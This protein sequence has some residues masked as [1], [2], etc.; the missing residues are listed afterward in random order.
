MT[1]A[2]DLSFV[3]TTL[4]DGSQSL[5]SLNMTTAMMVP[6]LGAINAVGYDAVEVMSTAEFKKCVRDLK[7]DP[8]QRLRVLRDGLPD[9]RRRFIRGRNIGTFQVF[10]DA[11]EHL[12]T[13]RLAANGVSELRISDSSN[14]P[15]RWAEQTAL[16]RANGLGVVLNVIYSLSPKHTDAY[17]AERARAAAAL[18]PDGIC[19]KDPGALITPDRTQTLVPIVLAAAGG[20]PVEFHT[21]CLTG[22]GAAC[23]FEAMRLGVAC[24]NTATPPLANGASNP[25]VFTALANARA[26]GRRPTID[27][28]LLP[29]VERHFTEVA[30]RNGFPVGRPLDF[31]YGQYVHQVPGGMISN[32]RFQLGRMGMAERLPAILEETGRVR[33]ELGHPIMVTP[34]SQFV[35]S[36]AAVNVITGQRY[37]VLTDEVIQFALGAWGEEEANGIDPDVRD[38]ILGS[39]RAKELARVAVPQPSLDEVRRR[40]GGPGV[41]DEAMLLRIATDAASV[42]AMR[43]G[44]ASLAPDG[45]AVPLT[46]LIARLDRLPSTRHVR[47]EKAGLSLTLARA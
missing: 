37:G 10:P 41:S 27:D 21:H 25:S 7:E 22:L 43:A 16:A 26:L 33:A 2:P 15:A 32:F 20:I 47:I 13:E 24:V 36:Q 3:D 19:L 12:W 31:D 18:K 11:V 44:G 39:A 14:T 4:R 17:Y 35:G 6:A 9:T 40:H 28:S 45:R 29:E 23:T 46:D 30:A 34:Y 1:R 38:R 42:E 5:W 8:W